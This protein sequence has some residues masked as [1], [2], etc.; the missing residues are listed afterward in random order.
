MSH[1]HHALP[2][3]LI[4][5][6]AI[7]KLSYSAPG[8]TSVIGGVCGTG[9]FVGVDTALTAHH[10]LSEVT[11]TPNSG[12]RHCALWIATR[13]GRL[14]DLTRDLV[15]FYPELD[16]TL[17]RF[18]APV[19]AAHVY[20]L[21]AY[22]ASAGLLVRGIGHLSDAMPRADAVWQ[23]DRLLINSITLD[24]AVR[25]R[26]G[27]IKRLVTLHVDADDVKIHGV[28]GFE[29]SFGSRVGM[30]G[31]PVVDEASGK[32]FGVL[33]LGLPVDRHE[34]TETFAIAIE[35]IRASLL[36]HRAPA[37]G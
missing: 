2:L 3:R 32:V 24:N 26:S 31:G 13:D 36:P 12:F 25:D 23:D 7:L 19:H 37:N 27:Y 29:L 30:S 33:S 21:P 18:P 28:H 15:H 5:A 8:D 22:P 20:R 16:T 14:Y 35:R 10:V 11:F 9:F 1:P 34:K 17:I 6:F 4:M